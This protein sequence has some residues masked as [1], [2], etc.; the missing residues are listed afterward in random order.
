MTIL[1]R[2]KT[3]LADD[4]LDNLAERGGRPIFPEDSHHHGLP[5][6]QLS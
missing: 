1:R 4:M 2:R 5:E 6:T 3:L